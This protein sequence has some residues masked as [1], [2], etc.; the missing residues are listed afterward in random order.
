M[1]I[2]LGSGGKQR[3]VEINTGTAVAQVSTLYV[4]LLQS[5]PSG[6]DGMSLS[7]LISAGQGNEF[8]I[9]ANFYTGRKA[10]T[11]GSITTNS[12][13]AV[14]YNNNSPAIEWTNTTGSTVSVAG[15]FITDA[16]S[17]SSGSVLW[18][19]TPDA[20]TASIVNTQTATINANDLM[21]KVD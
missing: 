1:G 14:C 13:G 17:G 16:S 11:V 5:A 6:M 10:V 2:V 9:N 12:N 7:T 19:G 18:V 4:G 3:A 8:T 20:G 15:F 21:L